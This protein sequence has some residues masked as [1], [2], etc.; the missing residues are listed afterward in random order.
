MKFGM[1]SWASMSALAATLLT[2]GT[3]ISAGNDETEVRKSAGQF[4]E[5]LNMMFKG[6]L[7]PMTKVWSHAK[8]VTYMGPGGEFLV[9]WSEVL[10]IWEKQAALKMGGQVEASEMQVNVGQDLAV[11]TN[12]EKGTNK[13]KDGQTQSVSIRSTSVFRKEKGEWKM[14][15]HH[16][17]LLSFLG[18]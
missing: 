12:Y 6:D 18:K 11:A 14:I 3:A 8:D 1:I 2:A 13:D 10:P 9:G 4:Y 5:A 16:T 17:D 7:D 15:G